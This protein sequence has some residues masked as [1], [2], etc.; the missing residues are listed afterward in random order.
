MEKIL[1]KWSYG[2]NGLSQYNFIEY[3]DPNFLNVEGFLYD[4]YFLYC[5]Y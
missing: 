4:I 5:V 1:K 2:L 3:N